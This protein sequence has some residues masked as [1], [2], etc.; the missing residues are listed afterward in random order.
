METLSVRAV[1]KIGEVF[2]MQNY[3]VTVI[4]GGL[5]G[6]EAAWQAAER[7]L[8]VLLYEMRP[9]KKTP[10]H[11]TGMLAELVCSNSL[12]ARSLNNAVGLLKEELKLLG[13]LIMECASA[14]EVPAGGAVAVDREVF[15]AMI[16]K[17][18]EEHPNIVIVREEILNIPEERPLIIATG[19]LTSDSLTKSINELAG[20]DYLYFYDAAAP[21]ITAESIDFNRVFRASRY[22]KGSD[23]YL[24]CPMNEEEYSRFWEALINGEKSI[25]HLPEEEKYFEGCMPVEEMASR[26]KE[27]VLFGPLKPVGLVDPVTGKQP[28]AVVQLRQDNLEATLFNMVGFQTQLK[29]PEQKRI[30]RMIPGLENAEFARFGMMHRNTFINAPRLLKSNYELKEFPGIFIAGQLSGVEGYVES[31]A[32]GLVAG[33]NASSYIK[34]EA[35]INLSRNTAIGSLGIYI[36]AAN[37]DHFQPMNVNFGMIAPPDVKIPK[38]Q[39]REYLARRALE[40]INLLLPFK[41]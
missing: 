40:E 25:P 6:S 41:L 14:T 20:E 12:R 15:A 13:S 33:I 11:F 27:T 19:P 23:D 30:F 3:D 32:S 24:N 34:G 38:K 28:H 18:I 7:G 39:R 9:E 10:A 1:S 26:G 35:S 8:K 2:L 37:P 5:A 17:R 31:T 36:T 22:N 16:T 29:W 21:I 4:G